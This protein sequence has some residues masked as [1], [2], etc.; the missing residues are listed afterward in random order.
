VPY[1]FGAPYYNDYACWPY[2]YN[3]PRQWSYDCY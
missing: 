1:S 3:R 2:G